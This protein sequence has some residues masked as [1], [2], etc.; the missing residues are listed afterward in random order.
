MGILT[1]SW[2]VVLACVAA[3]QPGAMKTLWAIESLDPGGARFAL[4][5][6]DFHLY[7]SRFPGG[8]LFI[9]GQS[10]P[11]RDWAPVHPGPA[12]A[13]AGGRPHTFEIRFGLEDPGAITACRL[14]IDLYDAHKD[15]PPTV[16]VRVNDFVGE[17]AAAPGTANAVELLPTDN[18]PQRLVVDVPPGDLRAG[19][20]T[21]TITSIAG[22]WM[23]YNR[24]ALEVSAEAGAS[25][26][27]ASTRIL[28]AWTRPVVEW[29][30]DRNRHQRV[31]L[32]I[33]HVGAPADALIGSTPVRLV[34]GRQEIDVPAPLV[35]ETTPWRV[36]LQ[37]AGRTVA[38]RTV[39]V[40]PVRP[41]EVHVLHHTH[42]DIGYTHV[43]SE[44]EAMQWRHLEQ[45][46]ELARATADYD[47]DA[48]FRW[49]PEGLWAV[50]SYL[51]QAPPEAAARLIDAVKQ[52]AI[53]L[54]ALYGNELTGLCRPEELF[55]LT[56]PA[57]RMAA[58][59]GLTIDSAMISDV[60]GVTWGLVPVLADAGVKY[61]SLA[62]NRG[63]RIGY[64]LS[65]W[66]DKPFY[67]QSPSG[68]HKVLTWM[69]GKGYSWFHGAWRGQ[70]TFEYDDVETAL[71]GEK[72]LDYLEALD[73][74]DY[75]Y[76]L[77]Q[78]RYNVGSDNGP[79]DPGLSDF[80]RDWNERHEIPH[81]VITTT[82]RM[83]RALEER[84][85]PDL[86]V[87]RG[88]FTPY[89]EDGAASSARETALNRRAAERLVQAGTL[90][91]LLDPPGYPHHDFEAAWRNVLL[92][93][94]H[95]W[96]SWNSISEPDSEF[97]LQQWAVKRGF[98][99]AADRL[100][101]DLLERAGAPL[102]GAADAVTDV[103]VIN[104]CSWIRSDLVEVPAG[105]NVAGERVVD[106]FGNVMPSQRLRSGALA[107]LA[108]DVPPQGAVRFTIGPGRP[109]L[110]SDVVANGQRLTNG[111][112]TVEVD[113]ATGAVRSL[114][115]RAVPAN[116]VDAEA[117]FGLNAYLYVAGRRPSSPQT[118]GP[119]RIEVIEH[120]PLVGSLRIE[121]EA[122]GCN[123]LWRELRVVA[124]Q[125]H[126]DIVNHLDKRRV[127]DPE[128]V[129][130]AFPLW[131]P[132]PVVRFDIAWGV[133]RLGRDQLPGAC[134][135]HVAVQR[136]VDVSNSDFGV[137]LA[138]VDAPL[139]EVGA[140]RADPIAVGWVD[141]L[142]PSA[143]LYSYVM[144]NYWE[145]NFL[146][147]QEG[148]VSF[149]YAL[150]PHRPFDAA[151]AHRFGAERSQPLI[152]VPARAGAVGPESPVP[153]L[154][155]DVVVTSLWPGGDGRWLT[156]RLF[157]AGEEPQPVP[158]AN[159]AL[160]P[161]WGITTIRCQH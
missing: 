109:D 86:P 84:Y 33:E 59:Y 37:V 8:P 9:V 85:G 31:R 93:D 130:F 80:V 1:A 151:T 29:D 70:D 161:P 154:P 68:E 140:I 88:D 136:W 144:N 147:G 16:R 99:E 119:V 32:L 36:S 73:R 129:H 159:Q 87:V 107:F 47:D 49:N 121:S 5:L 40:R 63:H 52:G 12:D 132:S 26:V 42:L 117:G 122:P 19:D 94:E 4:S 98:A 61:L 113:D 81:L 17:C 101:Q 103:I 62:P 46:V 51:A 156:A 120:G 92:Y 97:T 35:E 100:S 160:L 157:N 18:R 69:A 7:A 39:N 34:P 56:A 44:V 71:D 82:S 150:R 43:Q 126:L 142:E 139:V 137:T 24:V 105:W 91:A 124:G 102:A 123:G 106:A 108:L 134:K 50:E 128:S 143:Q 21:V 2:L 141:D 3:G 41:W 148:P 115:H 20:N 131:V 65:T 89:W 116:L 60:P 79:P 57:L 118:N 152:V 111:L 13:W 58:A 83:C 28:D 146:A 6:D 138:T 23:I 95:T 22:A 15:N 77:V 149:R 112:L 133:V 104:T 153:V 125:N 64:A 30:P 54:D 67:W 110:S 25:S 135:N 72:V 48:R 78:L 10:E 76:D 11:G 45:A 14:I 27:Q 75:P 155:E 127:L 158:V 74:E 145:T 55:Q 53:G 38:G 90:W 114:R 66:G 96:G